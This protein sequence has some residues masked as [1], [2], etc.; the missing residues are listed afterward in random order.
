MFFVAFIPDHAFDFALFLKPVLF[1]PP[2]RLQHGT[3]VAF[4]VFVGSVDFGNQED[5]DI[6]PPWRIS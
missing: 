6:G 5:N 1:G 4:Q 2:Y 3:Q